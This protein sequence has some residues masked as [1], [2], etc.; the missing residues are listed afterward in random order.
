VRAQTKARQARPARRPQPST[1]A[2][3]KATGTS[4]TVEQQARAPA[5]VPPLTALARVSLVWVSV[6]CLR[7][8]V[9]EPS[10]MDVRARVVGL[11]PLV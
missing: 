7:K 2:R 3:H 6:A 10:G 11:G 5:D 8:P 4:Q 9:G 1:Q